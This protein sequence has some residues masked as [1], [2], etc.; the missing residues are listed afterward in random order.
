MK[1]STVA[2]LILALLGMVQPAAADEKVFRQNEVREADL[3]DALTPKTAVP[4]EGGKTGRTR[5]IKIERDLAPHS[6]GPA[7]APAAAPAATKPAKASLLITFETNSAVL[8]SEARQSLDVVGNALK[9]EKLTG[10]NFSIEGHADPRGN[11]D[12]N[13]KLS[14]ER[15]EAVRQY[16]MQKH[17]LEASRLT[18]VGK[19][20]REPLNLRNPAA[21]ENRRV[22]IVTQTN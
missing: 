14:G 18:A 17:G 16:L 3:V 4:A 20:D 6:S 5:S 11:A 15:A 19:G 22:T 12:T 1:S 7:A 13:L 10:F 2:V 21:P 8:T 9:A